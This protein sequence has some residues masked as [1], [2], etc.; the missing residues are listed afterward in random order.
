MG[1]RARATRRRTERA[2]GGGRCTAARATIAPLLSGPL[3]LHA[4]ACLALALATFG[5]YLGDVSLGFLSL[6]DPDNVVNNPWIRAVTWPNVAHVLTQI[7]FA[8]F[9]PSLHLSYMLDAALGGLDPR[10]FHLSSNAWAALVAAEVYLLGVALLG[11]PLAA[12]AAAALFVVHPVHVEAVAWISSRKDLVAAAFGIAA[13]LAYMRWRR[14]GHPAAWYC[15]ALAFFAVAV[16]GKQSV[17]VLPALWGALDLLVEKRGLRGAVLDKLPF[18]GIAAVFTVRTLGAEPPTGYHPDLVIIGKGLAQSAALLAGLGPYTPIR[19]RPEATG[20]SAVLFA[21]LP[22]VAI[23]LAAAAWR[24]LPPLLAFLYLWTLLSLAPQQVMSF[25]HP[26]EDRYLFL[27]SIGACLLLGWAGAAAAKRFGRPGAVAAGAAAV[28]LGGA[29][30]HSTLASLADWRDPRSIWLTAASVSSDVDAFVYLGGEYQDAADQITERLAKERPRSPRDPRR[31]AAV[32]WRD[33]PRL[34]RLLAE[35]AAGTSG[36]AAETALRDRL[37]ELAWEQLERAARV[38]GPR[39]TPNLFFRRG[40]L[41]F[42]RGH[43]AEARAEFQ[44]ALEQSQLSPYGG[45]R[46]SLAV[47]CHHALGVIA[48]HESDYDEALKWLKMAEDEQT[49]AGGHWVPTITAERE[50]LEGIIASRGGG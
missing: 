46:D 21:A 11:R 31:L 50:R 41:Q 6:D 18:A 15:V 47:Y 13:T 17:V 8:K 38:Q 24:F 20:A 49:R 44:H 26:V 34:P 12:L 22:F 2:A 14:P 7:H 23:A 36:G 27:S 9:T 1:E 3:P 10:A 48:W 39:V 28:L 32:V 5:L 4:A 43:L 35:W 16:G 42:D 40:K 19:D 45:T 37:R 29:W 30:L 33:D 25:V